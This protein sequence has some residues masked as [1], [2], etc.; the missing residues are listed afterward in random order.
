M[1]ELL[2]RPA[3]PESMMTDTVELTLKPGLGRWGFVAAFGAAIGAC[4]TLDPLSGSLLRWLSVAGAVFVIG[5]AAWVTVAPRMRLRLT[6]EG[7]TFG[8]ARRRYCYRWSDVAEFH[9][10]DFG[11]N[12][13]VV[14]TFTPE[15]TEEA[16]VRSINQAFGRFDRILPDT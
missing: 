13:W 5:F 3:L 14:F 8:T 6:A 10:A 9:T 16:E 4:G 2:L 11:H 15:Y 12:R 7:F 1:I